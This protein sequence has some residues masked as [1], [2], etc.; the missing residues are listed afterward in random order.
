MPDPYKTPADMQDVYDEDAQKN[1]EFDREMGAY[2]RGQKNLTDEE[3]LERM[4]DI[5]AKRKQLKDNLLRIINNPE[6]QTLV[7]LLNQKVS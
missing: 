4:K 2:R 3:R 5:T 7:L 6:S 1:K